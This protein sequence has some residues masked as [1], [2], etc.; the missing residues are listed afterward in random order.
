MIPIFLAL[1]MWFGIADL[2]VNTP[3]VNDVVFD[4]ERSKR[5]PRDPQYLPLDRPCRPRRDGSPCQ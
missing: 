1:A 4:L 3:L 2:A 5:P